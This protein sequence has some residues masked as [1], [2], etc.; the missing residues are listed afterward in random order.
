[1]P[2]PAPNDLYTQ[3][4]RTLLEENRALQNELNHAAS[5]RKPLSRQQIAQLGASASRLEKLSKQ[6]R[7][8]VDEW[9]A[10]HE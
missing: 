6:V 10:T 3:R 8:L 1:M 2:N 9:A 5:F 7:E 4:W